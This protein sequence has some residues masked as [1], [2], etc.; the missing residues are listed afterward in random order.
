M[1]ENDVE[2]SR[3]GGKALTLDL[4]VPE[5]KGPVPAVIIVHG[6]GFARGNKRTYVTP[7]FDLLS[8]SGFAWFT[9]DYRMAPEFQLPHAT[10]DVANAIRWVRANAAK[11]HVDPNKIALA[12]ESAGGFLVA[13]AGVQAEADTRIAAVVDFYGPNDLV[14]Q[15][16]ERRAQPEDP[17]KPAGPGLKEF[18]GLRSWQQ[19]D[20]IEKLR[21][22]ADDIHPRGHAAVP[23]H[24][25][26]RRRAGAVSAVAED[27]RGDEDGRRA[28]RRDYGG[29]RPAWH[30]K[31]GGRCVDGALEAGNDPV[32]QEGSGC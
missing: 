31:L 17:A 21:C 20:A 16:E 12:G 3:P 30:G 28:V 22:V 23:V 32:A 7:L 24:S 14:L 29:W 1:E 25:R 2:Y 15:T 27:V 11:Y 8:V 9:I 6:G 26:H 13:Y 18:L 10:E 4:R 5:S 19:A